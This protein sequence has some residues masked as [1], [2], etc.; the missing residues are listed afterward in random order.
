MLD[1]TI[2][3]ANILGIGTV[4]STSAGKTPL[5]MSFSKTNATKMLNDSGTTITRIASIMEGKMTTSQVSQSNLWDGYKVTSLIAEDIKDLV[6]ERETIIYKV[7][8]LFDANSTLKGYVPSYNEI[9][10]LS[11]SDYDKFNAL[12]A[13]LVGNNKIS[14]YDEMVFVVNSADVNYFTSSIQSY[15]STEYGIMNGVVWTIVQWIGTPLAPSASFAFS[16]SANISH[17][18][19]IKVD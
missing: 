15:G 14:A 3:G 10:A 13:Q 2:S 11:E 18:P 12:C 6:N 9:A 4:K 7:Y 16:H 19:F 5:F 1:D 8:H 17:R